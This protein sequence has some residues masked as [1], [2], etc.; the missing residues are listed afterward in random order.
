MTTQQNEQYVVDTHIKH[1]DAVKSFWK[2]WNKFGGRATRQEYFHGFIHVF[3]LAAAYTVLVGII[4][5]VGGIAIGS[6]ASPTISK[7]SNYYSYSINTSTASNAAVGTIILTAVIVLISIAFVVAV[8]VPYLS[9]FIRR[10]R[11]AGVNNGQIGLYYGVVIGGSILSALLFLVV[12]GILGFYFIAFVGI[13][14]SA[15]AFCAPSRQ[16]P[17][18]Y[19]FLTVAIGDYKVPPVH[20]VVSVQP[21]AP[22]APAAP[23]APVAPTTPVQSISPEEAA[24]AAAIFE[25]NMGED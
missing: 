18:V 6:S 7:G 1:I 21:V 9:L 14:G 22:A 25:S 15:I 4:T 17:A 16:E 5:L 12:I 2:H 13:L 8:G 19:S 24:R 10:L 11:S 3:Y 23:A 20:P